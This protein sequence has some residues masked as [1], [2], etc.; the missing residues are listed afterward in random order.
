MKVVPLEIAMACYR[1][2]PSISIPGAEVHSS[3][4]CP[5]LCSQR[6]LETFSYLILYQW[7]KAPEQLCGPNR[8]LIPPQAGY[9]PK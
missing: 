9:I 6:D 7:T 2:P 4:T 3:Q 5:A 1:G 8:H